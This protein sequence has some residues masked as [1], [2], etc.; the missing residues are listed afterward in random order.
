[1]YT[2]EHGRHT[3][4]NARNPFAVLLHAAFPKGDGYTIGKRELGRISGNTGPLA[5]LMLFLQ[6][7]RFPS[8]HCGHDSDFSI[9]RIV[10]VML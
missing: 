1:M 4:S 2:R 9:T 3:H 7:P 5:I 10:F 8:P 6:V